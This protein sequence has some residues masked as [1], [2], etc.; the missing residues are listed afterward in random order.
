MGKNFIKNNQS[1][2]PTADSNPVSQY[3][4]SGHPIDPTSKYFIFVEKPVNDVDISNISFVSDE[5]SIT[6]YIQSKE[7]LKVTY[8]KTE[9]KAP[10]SKIVPFG[11]TIRFL[12]NGTP[13]L[14]LEQ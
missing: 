14:P 13:Y 1:L 2:R 7:N 9:T 8:V 3:L 11:K 4:G 10:K 5:I 12:T 6:N